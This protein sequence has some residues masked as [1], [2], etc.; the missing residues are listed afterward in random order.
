MIRRHQ[1]GLVLLQ[2]LLAFLWVWCLLLVAFGA[3]VR[4]SDAG[5]GCPDW[6]TCYGKLT[7]PKAHEVDAVQANF[8][9]QAV[10]IHKAWPEQVHR[11]IAAVLGVL[12]L[13]AVILA[14][15][16]TSLRLASR[17]RVHLPILLGVLGVG[18][19]ILSYVIEQPQLSGVF[20]VL[21]ELVLFYGAYSA[22]RDFRAPHGHLVAML[23]LTLGLVCFQALL[24]MW[25]V[26]LKVKP[27]VVTSHLLGGMA[28][29]AMI[30]ICAL[31]AYRRDHGI[32]ARS[33]N[34]K[35][36]AQ[37]LVRIGLVLLVAQITLGG[38]VSTNYAALACPDFP[39][40]QG[41]WWPNLDFR[42][43]FVIWRGIGVNYEGGVLDAPARA[44]VH[45]AHRLG[46]VIVGLY[47]LGLA[48][49]AMRRRGGSLYPARQLQAPGLLVLACLIIQIALGISNVVFALPL[50]VAVAHNGMAALLLCA[51]IWLAW[52]SQA[53]DFR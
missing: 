28:T 30:L 33:S 12:V 42:E 47:L 29:L 45:V 14:R 6:P 20:F 48:L 4:L 13:F 9:G 31:L 19:A 15:D 21:G 10:E 46:A 53:E 3:F 37:W 16:L 18:L 7:W 34:A 23:T 11:F 50:W 17:M 8:P 27:A 2:R 44:A 1:G 38:W 52:R 32:K 22:Y 36:S 51:M 5:L 41:Q 43:G 40:C 26:T 35:R 25:T 49:Y 39:K 24:G